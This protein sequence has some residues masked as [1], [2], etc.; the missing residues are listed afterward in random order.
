MPRRVPRG[1]P[2]ER[3]RARQVVRQLATTPC[4]LKWSDALGRTS[5][6]TGG[7]GVETL[8]GNVLWHS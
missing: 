7:R 8:A 2:A 1:L 4:R 6:R 3:F 5:S